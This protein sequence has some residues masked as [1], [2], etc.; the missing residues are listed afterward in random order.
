MNKKDQSNM[1]RIKTYNEFTNENRDNEF[2][3]DILNEAIDPIT[4]AFA[5]GAIG[6]AFAGDIKSMYTKR[7]ISKSNLNELRE[8]LAK[9]RAKL[10][11]ELRK[12]DENSAVETQ[13]NIDH[14]EARI[15]ILNDEFRDSEKSI[16]SYENDKAVQKELEMELMSIDDRSRNKIIKS[17]K[18][19]IKD[20]K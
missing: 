20:L 18:K 12:G 19:E 14:I 16:D 13:E 15:D 1:P 8:L 5:V 7:K 10:K 3:D 4:L 9:E 11:K 17:A 6:I 2:N